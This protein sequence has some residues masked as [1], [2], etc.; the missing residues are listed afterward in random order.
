MSRFR[1]AMFG[2][3]SSYLQLGASAVYS[4]ASI[5]LA[6]HYLSK[7][8]FALWAVS[9]SIGAYLNLVDFGMSTSVARLL[10]DYKDQR[11][12]R[13]Y[14]SLILTGWLVLFVQGFLLLAICFASGPWLATLV[15]IP[16]DLRR[17]FIVLM[18][19]QGVYLG[20]TFALRIFGNLLYAHQRL[21]LINYTQ[22]AMVGVWLALLW[23]F[24]DL[25]C[26]V[27]S[28]LWSGLV[29][30][31]MI[32]TVQFYMCLRLGL[33]PHSGEWGRPSW[34]HFRELFGYGKDLFL[35]ALGG[36]MILASQTMIITRRLGLESAAI[37]AVG[38]KAYNMLSQVTWRIYDSSAAGLA[39]MLARGERVLLLERYRTVVIVSASFA[40]FCA[41]CYALCNS[42]FVTVWMHGK[43]AWPP[44]NDLLLGA[45]LILS[46][47]VHSHSSLI[48]LTKD[49]RFMRYIYF[50]EGAAFVG[51]AIVLARVGGLPAIIGSSIL[52]SITFT[53]AYGTRRIARLFGLPLHEVAWHWLAVM[54]G[55]V[56]RWAPV[57]AVAWFVT[58]PLPPLARLIL[59]ALVC[60]TVGIVLFIRYGVPA[61]LR[62]ELIQ[63]FPAFAKPLSRFPRIRSLA[64]L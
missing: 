24:F 7:E 18:Y 26:G 27:L 17:E 20:V 63:R 46:A 64:G 53:F 15:D 1:R 14:G 60:G 45:W 51:L 35:V 41:V 57:A 43:I 25:G 11:G 16:A 9:T 13:V 50:V 10:I 19:W 31:I 4:L 23:W 52:C 8:R 62:D 55:V 54:W 49:L 56:W 61:Q 40:G 58:R 32:F 29:G 38:T 28:P 42:A 3:L 37:W 44:F 21:D 34:A 33:F 36:Q 6:L 5:P 2:A 30:V 48:L 59:M 39:E 12:G 22:T 47:V